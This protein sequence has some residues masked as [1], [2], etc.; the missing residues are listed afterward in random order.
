M[1]RPATPA[2]EPAI[3]AVN[4]SAFF[5]EGLLGACIH[6]HRHQYPADVAIFFHARI[7]ADF[8]EPRNRL[9]VATVTENGA[10]KIAG[11]ATWQRQG[12]DSG[13]QKIIEE[14]E[15]PGPDA[16]AALE[17]TQNR[18]IDPSK[19]N[20]L[21]EAY[22]FF[23]YHW[24]PITNGLPRKHNW[25]LRVCAVHKDYAG[26]GIGREL[27]QWGLDRAREENVHASVTS[28]YENEKF[29]LRCGYDEIVG[30]CSEGEGNPLAETG[31]PGGDI[32]FM[33]AKERK[34]DE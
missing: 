1:I 16:F 5:E 3:V 28:S 2:D 6:P 34:V 9:I 24:D 13:A 22:P 29:Y 27:V 20:I 12:D 31:V 4:T 25:Y 10:E 14:W 8:H 18:A 15:G 11:A 30:N 26:R 21:A 33:W 7:R 17:R 19:A 32:L 23:K